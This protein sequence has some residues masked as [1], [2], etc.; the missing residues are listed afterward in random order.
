MTR[1]ERLE[2]KI[3]RRHEWADKRETKAAAVFKAGEPFTSDIAFNTQTGHIP[4]RARLIAREDRAHESLQVAQ[5][6]RAKADGLERQLDRTVFSDDENATEAL[7]ARAAENEQKR[8]RMTL[9]NK[10]FRKGDAAG[11]AAIGV[12]LDNLR[13]RVADLESWQDKQPFAKY[14]LTNIGARIRADRKRIGEVKRRQERAASAEAQGGV[15]AEYVGE[16]ARVT[17]AEK[18][19]R[20]VLDALRAWGS[21]GGG[22]WTGRTETLPEIVRAELPDT[23]PCQDEHAAEAASTEVQADSAGT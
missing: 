17:F 6:H 1:R 8:D 19:E 20:D 23:T 11:L 4:F 9:I 14:E 13:A 15:S 3:E 16:Y 7:E 5:H 10:L 12:N 22:A 18:P 2:A 21:W